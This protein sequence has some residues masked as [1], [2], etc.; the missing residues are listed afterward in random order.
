MKIT[1][2]VLIKL[3]KEQVEKKYVI[4]M[5]FSGRSTLSGKDFN[6]NEEAEKEAEKL[7][8]LAKLNNFDIEYKVIEK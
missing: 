8:K 6:S 5:S 2:K 1:K 3:I 7:R 4:K